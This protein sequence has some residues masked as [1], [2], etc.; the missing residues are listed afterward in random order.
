MNEIDQFGNLLQVTKTMTIEEGTP[1]DLWYEE[2]YYKDDIVDVFEE[3]DQTVISTDDYEKQLMD[4]E[5]K[6]QKLS[7]RK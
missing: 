6:D 2:I 7:R 5:I 1:Y 4:S 3:S